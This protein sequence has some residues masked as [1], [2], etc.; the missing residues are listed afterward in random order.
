MKN[1]RYFVFLVL[2]LFI[3][4]ITCYA[5]NEVDYDITGYYVD[6]NLNVDG[7]MSVKE[8]ILM[9]GSFNGYERRTKIKSHG[10]WY[11]NST[12]NFEASPIY[13]GTSIAGINVF[14]RKLDRKEK[15]FELVNKGGFKS[16]NLVM[17][18]YTG[19][20]NVYTLADNGYGK[21]IRMYHPNSSGTYAFLI[22]YVVSDVVVIHDDVA[23]F[24]WNFIGDDFTDTL[25]DVEI[26]VNLPES[27]SS[28]NFKFWAH[29]ELTGVINKLED[30]DGNP[31]G[32][33]ATAPKI[34]S[35]SMMDIR[36]TF[37]KGLIE[38]SGSLNHSHV[39]AMSEILKIEKQRADDANFRRMVARIAN[40]ILNGLDIFYILLIFIF[41][42]YLF[43]KYD[44]EYKSEFDQE[45]YRDFLDNYRPEELNY[46]MN[47]NV[48]NNAF[49]ASF[50]NLIY[51][52]KI[53]IINP[54]QE[55]DTAFKIC[56]R[57]NLSS[58]ETILVSMLFDLVG[59]GDAF[60]LKQLKKFT[61]S[62]SKGPRFAS[63]FGSWKIAVTNDCKNKKIYERFNGLRII[64]ILLACI[65]IGI[66]F[67]ALVW[68]MISPFVILAFIL[69]II[70]VI[71]ASV[72][73]RRS[74]EANE[75]YHKAKAIKRFLNDFGSF[76]GKEIPEIKLWDK[77]L[78]YATA[79]GIASKV[80]KSMTKLLKN[81]EI[82]S[83]D[84]TYLSTN[85]LIFI[86]NHMDI[87]HSI[88][89]SIGSSI[90]S[91]VSSSIA[92]SV[93]SS[94]S[95]GGGGFSSG[96]GGGGGGGGGGGF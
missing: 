76:K 95:G 19:Q 86:G 38:D 80:E 12:V 68:E 32:V 2:S 26:H 16:F 60:T 6:A 57:S 90:S 65:G 37:D 96:A 48:D 64:L 39:D 67:L 59:D 9:K 93:S 49:S 8:M 71:Y 22:S 58:G 53:E 84:T 69:G 3:F 11:E 94:S 51:Q 77:Y 28:D 17:S 91:A 55:G 50:L 31:S 40:F 4:N 45:Y 13:N 83:L 66:N 27:D 41:T 30:K 92:S 35:R 47:H 89:S 70:F 74:K 79:F 14:G 43:F 1:L 25:R 52:H 88:N 61:R 87:N 82:N 7:S 75:D 21:N 72:F 81:A 73:T 23:E 33:V 5:A 18:A 44:K 20:S 78:V 54:E 34:K 29:G 42:L 10:E 85:H 63:R 36:M 56:D 15:G 62:S 46:L 24:Y